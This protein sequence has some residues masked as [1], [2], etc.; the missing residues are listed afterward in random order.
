MIT[1]TFHEHMKYMLR[2]KDGEKLSLECII[3]M[4]SEWSNKW[5]MFTLIGHGLLGM[6][7]II[8]P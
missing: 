5:F 1:Y 6:F 2:R 7:D 8:E 4:S 3:D